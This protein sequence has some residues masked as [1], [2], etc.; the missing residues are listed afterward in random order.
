M[1]IVWF[2]HQMD[3]PDETKSSMRLTRFHYYFSIT[4]RDGGFFSLEMDFSPVPAPGETGKD[5]LKRAFKS[6]ETL[7]DGEL[8]EDQ[9]F[10]FGKTPTFTDTS[11]STSVG[12]DY[13]GVWRDRSSWLFRHLVQ[14]LIPL[15]KL[16]EDRFVRLRCSLEGRYVKSREGEANLSLRLA[17]RRRLNIRVM[18]RI[19]ALPGLSVSPEARRELD[20]L[21]R[22]LSDYREDPRKLL[23]T[24]KES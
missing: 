8:L 17:L 22:L 14:P 16:D 18:E 9:S 23:E 15:S 11:H 19:L 6:V 24:W 2:N 10:T 1:G 7:L 21:K 13:E 5:A 3:D 4:G 12:Y 20:E